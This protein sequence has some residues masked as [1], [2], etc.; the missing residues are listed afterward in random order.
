VDREEDNGKQNVEKHDVRCF[1][2][3]TLADL[4]RRGNVTDAK[5]NH[6]PGS[7]RPFQ[8]QSA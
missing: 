6:A 3:F 7:A 5:T 8:K 4:I 1:S 2:L